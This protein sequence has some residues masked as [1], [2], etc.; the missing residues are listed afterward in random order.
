MM[1]KLQLIPLNRLLPSPTNPRKNFPEKGM[2]E[3]AESIA[4]K[5]VLQNIVVRVHPKKESFYEIV[6]G[7]RRYKA[8]LLAQKE[9][10][11]A[12][13]RDLSDTDVIEIQSIENDQREDV[14]PLEQAVSYK[15]L[16][17]KCG[18]DIE[19]IHT[20]IHKDKTF[21]AQRLQL[22]NLIEKAKEYFWNGDISVT[23]A[24][25]LAR[26]T[27][28]QQA[29]ALRRLIQNE[30]EYENG[31]QMRY[32]RVASISEFDAWLNATIYLDLHSAPFPKDNA[33][34]LPQAGSCTMCPKRTGF[35]SD[36]FPDI[37]KK[38]TCTDAGCF[39]AKREA[40]VQMQIEQHKEEGVELVKITDQWSSST[41]DVIGQQDYK[42]LSWKEAKKAKKVT[43]AIF[44]DDERKGEVVAITLRNQNSDSATPKEL[45][46][47][48]KAERKKKSDANKKRKQTIQIR[49]AVLKAI[50]GKTNTLPM[51]VL[52]EIAV[53]YF[54]DKRHDQKVAMC[55][56]LA[57]EVKRGR[58]GSFDTQ[59][60]LRT[61]LR[62]KVINPFALFLGIYLFDKTI[63]TEYHHPS[64]TP[65]R[66]Y[67]KKYKI[68]WKKIESSIKNPAKKR[69]KIAKGKKAV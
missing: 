4:E 55:H 21:I 20:K 12:T 30:E 64:D 65:L 29:Q 49:Q 17:D 35:N 31:K 53:D 41:P 33:E 67:A 23:H 46:A 37:R 60:T 11:P 44:V 59:G 38:D 48:E 66:E 8:S 7:E 40:F 24:I 58:Y 61:H 47:K 45:T 10:I 36:L 57:G 26:L 13:V 25:K 69:V 52:M 34:L 16:I 63:I 42:I 6:C 43:Q 18:Y 68:D 54:K 2:Q 56:F 28:E 5:G 32:K 15:N 22:L 19:K 3:L 50:M 9:D 62:N 39:N 14:H 51:D 27:Q 1:D